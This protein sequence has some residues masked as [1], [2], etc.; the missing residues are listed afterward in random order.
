MTIRI[1]ELRFPP[2]FIT[3]AVA[4]IDT[5]AR[6]VRTL[7]AAG[8]DPTPMSDAAALLIESK[9]LRSPMDLV[10]AEIANTRCMPILRDETYRSEGEALNAA[11]RILYVTQGGMERRPDV[12]NDVAEELRQLERDFEEFSRRLQA[13]RDRYT[14]TL[15]SA[16]ESL[17]RP[18]ELV[19]RS[20]TPIEPPVEIPSS[21]VPGEYGDLVDS[22]GLSGRA[23]AALE[24][25][26]ITTVTQ[27]SQM[28]N[29]QLRRVAGIGPETI[30]RIRERVP[31][32]QAP[33][34]RAT[35]RSADHAKRER[36]P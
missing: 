7:W 13:M 24:V 4:I 26:G 12:P 25:A 21:P 27:L 28:T 10:G 9:N 3:G 14:A 35:T 29:A 5:G 36:D 19:D 1:A 6:L 16:V 22:L 2:D 15:A 33:P 20:E 23:Q 30:R 34:K 11:D 8:A 32:G 18:I 17:W 31:I